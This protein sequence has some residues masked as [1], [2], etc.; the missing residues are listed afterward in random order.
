MNTNLIISVFVNLL[1]GLGIF[2]LGMKYI[3]EGLQA[4]A[5][6]RMMRKL[7]GYVTDKRVL[8]VGV[9]TLVTCIVQSSSITTVMVVGLVNGGLMTLKQAI[10]VI[11]GANIGTTITGWV[12]TLKIGKY[13]LPILGLSAFVFLFFRN[14]RLRYIGMAV[15]GVGMIFFSLELMKNGLKPLRGDPQFVR[16]VSC[17]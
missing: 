10:G 3:S 5:G 15:M 4:V 6:E 14:E 13:S 1:G 9:G 16:V 12:L 7:I 2:L 11:F 17:L 8:A